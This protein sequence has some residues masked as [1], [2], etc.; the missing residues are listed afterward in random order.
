MR[1]ACKDRLL[2]STRSGPYTHLYLWLYGL[3]FLTIVYG[4]RLYSG[5]TD[6]AADLQRPRTS[7]RIVGAEGGAE[8][9]DIPIFR[10]LEV[11]TT[12]PG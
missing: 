3:T 7:V 4:Q 5:T 1:T 9:D 11:I 10:G 2:L 6:F 12:T 8:R